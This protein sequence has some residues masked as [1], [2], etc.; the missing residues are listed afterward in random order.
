VNGVDITD[1]M[2][3]LDMLQKEAD[4]WVWYLDV[5]EPGFRFVST[6]RWLRIRS[7]AGHLAAERGLLVDVS[8]AYLDARVH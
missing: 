2:G 3:E 6:D 4:G 1:H 8:N 7:E 5:Q